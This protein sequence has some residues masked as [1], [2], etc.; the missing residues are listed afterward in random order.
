MVHNI[1]LAARLPIYP[2]THNTYYVYRLGLQRARDRICRICPVRSPSELPR[3]ILLSLL[4]TYISSDQSIS[5]PIPVY[6]LI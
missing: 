1:L 5:I 4:Y 2:P 6:M 3:T